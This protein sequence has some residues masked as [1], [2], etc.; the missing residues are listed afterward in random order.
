MAPSYTSFPFPKALF[1]RFVLE[2]NGEPCHLAT[3]QYSGPACINV[4]QLAA[5]LDHKPSSA[6]LH[7]LVHD[8]KTVAKLDTNNAA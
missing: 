5:M 1:E 7:G 2:R 6:C 3:V 8:V 4:G